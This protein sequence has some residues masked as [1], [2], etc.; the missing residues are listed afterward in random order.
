[1]SEA[2]SATPETEAPES[3]VEEHEVE[4]PEI[5]DGDEAE[6]DE[7]GEGEGERRAKATDWEKQAHDKAGLAAKERS[8]R[9]AAERQNAELLSRIEQIEARTSGKQSDDIADL[10][11]A[12]RDDDDEPITDLAQIKKVLKTFIARQADDDK[13]EGERQNYIKSTRAVSEGMSAFEADF[14]EEHPDYY[15]AATFYRQQRVAELEDLGYVGARLN[16]K[17]ASE[18]F[19]LTND[20]MKSGRDPAEAVYNMAKRR[21]FASGKAAATDKLQKLQRAS[22]TAGGPRGKGADNGLTWGEVAK[23]KGPARDKAFEKLRARE[24]GKA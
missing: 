24:L 15:K 17:L 11:A 23:L 22:A 6:G 1:M 5:E 16:Q 20:V 13:A 9:R 14:A 21:G 12:L 4:T 8:R 2:P 18:L 19:G 7:E 10:V 3:E